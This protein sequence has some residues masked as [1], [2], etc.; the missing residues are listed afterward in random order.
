MAFWDFR[1][2]WFAVFV[3]R[4]WGEMVGS[5]DADWWREFDSGMDLVG[6]VSRQN[7]SQK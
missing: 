4:N 2:R 3:D 1:I 5:G 6:G 7:W